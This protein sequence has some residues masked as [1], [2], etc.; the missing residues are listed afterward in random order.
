VLPLSYIVLPALALFM[1]GNP[2]PAVLI[3]G[4][5]LVGMWLYAR[6]DHD[7]AEEGAG[8]G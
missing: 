5:N 4:V 7:V 1:K 3:W 2:W 8:V 6:G